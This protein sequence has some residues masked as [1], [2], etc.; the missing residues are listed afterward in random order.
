M[1]WEARAVPDRVSDGQFTSHLVAG[2]RE[3]IEEK[4]AQLVYLSPCS[5]DFSSIENCLSKFKELLRSQAA[6]SY[7]QF[8]TC[9][10]ARHYW[11]VQ[12][13]W[14]LYFSQLRSSIITQTSR[15]V[16]LVRLS[17][18]TCSTF[19]DPGIQLVVDFQ[20]RSIRVVANLTYQIIWFA[21]EK[22]QLI[23]H[24]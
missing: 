11:L 10:F 2:V 21:Q 22:I 7:E 13:L 20:S 18:S 8:E 24:E 17:G 23:R 14:L 1:N 6:R 3:A 16:R 15:T 5:P 9:Y 19:L 12:T 4:G